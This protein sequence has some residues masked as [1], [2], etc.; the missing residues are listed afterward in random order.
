[1]TLLHY[2]ATTDNCLRSLGF[3]QVIA[4][5]SP[6]SSAA[7]VVSNSAIN[8]LRGIWN[9]L[10]RQG[11][12]ALV[13]DAPILAI[14]AHTKRYLSLANFLGGRDPHREH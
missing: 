5:V 4:A 12:I 8:T 10:K 6:R 14:F 2:A 13:F 11:D 9:R 3:H 1:M 7:L